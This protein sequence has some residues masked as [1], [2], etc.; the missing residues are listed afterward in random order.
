[1]T[2]AGIL[3]ILLFFGLVLVC[4]KPLGV[5]MARVFEGER[6]FLHPVLR[7]LEVLTYK[8]VGVREET[9]QKWTEYAASL[10]SFSIFSFLFVYLLQ[11]LQQRMPEFIACFR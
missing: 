7:W 6:T 1:M 3:Q 5:F 2:T 8:A 10:V 9:E 11:R 4:A